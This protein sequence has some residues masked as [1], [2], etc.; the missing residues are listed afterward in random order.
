[1]NSFLAY[2]SGIPDVFISAIVG[3]VFGLLGAFVGAAFGKL[4]LVKSV[5]LFPIIAIAVSFPIAKTFVLP[6]INEARLNVG[7]PKQLDESTIH[8]AT[9]LTNTVVEYQYHLVGN[10]PQNFQALSV[11]TMN[12]DDICKNWKADFDAS[13]ATRIDYVYRWDTGSDRFSVSPQDCR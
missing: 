8:E 4:G 10:I 1:M 6:A 12:I 13:R 3:G 2:L 7:L 9:R 11:K 5:G